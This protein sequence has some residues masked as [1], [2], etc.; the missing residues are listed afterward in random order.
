MAL[1]DGQV[2]QSDNPVV[3]D[4]VILREVPR[5]GIRLS[6][7]VRLQTV[8]RL[9]VVLVPMTHRGAALCVP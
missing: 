2:D 1:T 3:F 8:H 5:N 6:A 9:A 7:V 4:A